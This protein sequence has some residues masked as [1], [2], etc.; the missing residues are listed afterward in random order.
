MLNP[1]YAGGFEM[2]PFPERFACMYF[3]PNPNRPFV[4]LSVGVKTLTHDRSGI[5]LVHHKVVVIE[6]GEGEDLHSV[7]LTP[8]QARGLA[9]SLEEYAT[10]ID[11]DE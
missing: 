9:K 8:K 5:S 2:N 11:G 10:T 4:T 1:K 6:T 3:Q 7:D